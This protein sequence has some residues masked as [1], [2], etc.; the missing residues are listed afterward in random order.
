M[1]RKRVSR[2]PALSTTLLDIYEDEIGKT[3]SSAFVDT[4]SADGKRITRTEHLIFAPPPTLPLT[5]PVAS[6]ENVIDFLPWETQPPPTENI[7]DA[8]RKV[9]RKNPYFVTTVQ[10]FFNCAFC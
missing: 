10:F 4:L 7:P 5:P 8:D 3:S 9:K 2:L 6:H 1:S